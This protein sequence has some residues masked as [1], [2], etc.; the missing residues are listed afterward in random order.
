MSSLAIPA[1]PE[2]ARDAAIPVRSLHDEVIARL[3]D[4]IV[5]GEFAPGQRIPERE[6]CLRFGISR[7]PLREALK[8]LA[9]EGLID[10]RPNRGA[11][12]APLTVAELE[13]TV[14]VMTPLEE[15]AGRLAAARAGDAAI[16]EI[17]ALHYQMLAHHAR[18]ELSPYFRLNQAIHR[19]IVQ[20]SGNATLAATYGALNARIRRFRYMANLSRER[21]DGAVAEHNRIIDALAA[22]DGERLGRLLAEHL[23]NKCESVKAALQSGG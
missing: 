16:A 13:A 22:R 3:R 10:L 1:E 18:G 5:E 20:A 7:T 19:A 4:M 15:L 9:A 2:R 14:E 12:V 17:R 21:W 11:A 8:V 23:R 6:L